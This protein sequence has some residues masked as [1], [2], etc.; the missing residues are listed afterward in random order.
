[1]NRASKALKGLFLATN[2]AIV[3]NQ[4]PNVV[5]QA[6]TSTPAPAA[7]QLDAQSQALYARLGQLGE[8]MASAQNANEIVANSLAQA[9]L[10]VQLVSR[11]SQEARASLIR[12]LADSVYM[13]TM[14]S[15]AGD[16]MTTSRLA[17]LK[18]YLG[19]QML[20]RKLAAY[21]TY[22]IIQSDHAAQANMPNANLDQVHERYIVRL[23]E[24][25]QLYP[26]GQDVPEAVLEIAG[27]CET[28]GK[29]A[30][31]RAWYQYLATNHADSRVA[32]KARGAVERLGLEGQPMQLAL[33][34]LKNEEGRVDNPVD[35]DEFRG[36]LVI[37]YFW[38]SWDQHSGTDF[39]TLQKLMERYQANGLELLCV[40]L[41]NDPQDARTF[42]NG[43]AVPG[44]HVFQRGGID[45]RIAQRY[46]IMSLPRWLLVGTNGKVL[47]SG[48]HLGPVETKIDSMF[49]VAKAQ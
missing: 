22:R 6:P 5:A 35:I 2:L 33:P 42:L 17:G 40:N 39:A 11:S 3:A 25:V 18:N 13:A 34:S 30:D 12:Q 28:L 14:N 21:V 24:Y 23:N 44:V 47:N 10:L 20:D 32:V 43:T 27:M 7:V 1:M 48:T 9:D 26:D 19:Q 31:A 15:Q 37:V 49:G 8:Q 36:K 41:D 16:M 46:G 45:G 29:P 38:A 4:C